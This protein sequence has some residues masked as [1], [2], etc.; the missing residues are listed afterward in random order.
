VP[1]HVLLR[2]FHGAPQHRLGLMGVHVRLQMQLGQ[3]G[4]GVELNIEVGQ[5]LGYAPRLLQVLAR[6]IDVLGVGHEDLAHLQVCPRLDLRRRHK[7][8]ERLK[9]LDA[10][11]DVGRLRGAEVLRQAEERYVAGVLGR[12]RRRAGQCTHFGPRRI[13]FVYRVI[14]LSIRDCARWRCVGQGWH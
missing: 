7:C 11:L 4:S 8:E 1:V 2:K 14:L 5:R 3:Q 12:S 10:S 6:Q 13:R 9:T